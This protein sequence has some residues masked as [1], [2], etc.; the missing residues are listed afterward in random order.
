MFSVSP[1]APGGPRN[2]DSFT[3]NLQLFPWL[4]VFCL[5]LLWSGFART[6]QWHVSNCFREDFKNIKM[7]NRLRTQG[8][9]A[10]FAVQINL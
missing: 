9:L 10:S 2:K 3:W 8:S 6:K 7:E 5:A 1:Q 4:R